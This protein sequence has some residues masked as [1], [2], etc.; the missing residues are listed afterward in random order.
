MLQADNPNVNQ[1]NKI[2]NDLNNNMSIESKLSYVRMQEEILR[3][4]MSITLEELGINNTFEV[5]R[6][7]EPDAVSPPSVTQNRK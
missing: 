3:E 5:V 6:V 4:H 1:E 7:S 2:A